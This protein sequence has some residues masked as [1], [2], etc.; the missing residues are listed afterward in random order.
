VGDQNLDWS[1]GGGGRNRTANLRSGALGGWTWALEKGV[2]WDSGCENAFR[3]RL[4][5][6]ASSDALWA[7]RLAP[8][9][10]RLGPAPR[11][12]SVRGQLGLDGIVM[13]CAPA[14]DGLIRFEGLDVSIASRSDCRATVGFAG[15]IL[16][17][18]PAS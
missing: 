1:L 2:G 18:S 17:C 16:A 7:S 14:I 4:I 6:R 15:S 8:P 12:L 5:F 11:P 3:Q 13:A 10:K 9:C